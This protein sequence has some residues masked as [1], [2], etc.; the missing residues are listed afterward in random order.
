MSNLWNAFKAEIQQNVSYAKGIVCSIYDMVMEQV[1]RYFI[2]LL[3]LII[4][5]IPH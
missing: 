1:N 2:Y 5:S 4:R 3:K